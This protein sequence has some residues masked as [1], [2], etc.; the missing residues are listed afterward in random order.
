MKM[1]G[2]QVPPSWSSFLVLTARFW[3]CS[4][5]DARRV[6]QDRTSST[7][8]VPAGAGSAAARVLRAVMA[9]RNFMV[10]VKV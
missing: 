1:T 2:G 5:L 9:K 6:F 3:G 7:L 8:T 10:S 4:A